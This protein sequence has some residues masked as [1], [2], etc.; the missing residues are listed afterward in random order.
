[1]KKYLFILIIISGIFTSCKNGDWEFP[2]YDYTAVYFAYQTPV[3]T[4]VIGEDVY[5][6]SLD[7]EH[8]CQIMA[9]MGGVYEN[10]AD[11]EI[12]FRV[13]NA[14]CNG[15]TFD[16]G[17]DVKP[18]PSN[19]YS[20]SSTDKIV[21]KKDEILG[22]VVVQLTDAFFTDP[23]AVKN[24]YVIPL[25]MNDVKNADKILTGTPLVDNPSRVKTDDWDVLPKDYILYAVKYISKYHANYLRRGKDVI[26]GEKNETVIRHKEYVEKDEA[27]GTYTR[28]LNTVELPL[29][30]T[31]AVG[32][33]LDCTLLLTFDDSGK[34]TV[35]SGSE[36]VAMSGSGQY[37]A[38]GEKKSWGDKDRDAIYLNYNIDFGKMQVS[39]V[40]TLV[41]RDRG[42]KPETFKPVLK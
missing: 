28:S 18:M 7:N 8:K 21:I 40:D 27:V 4:I 1:M 34:C 24:T 22:G 26:T 30:I 14:L 32:N 3:R 12:G 5:D 20:L 37:V 9:T 2:D 11:V 23:L 33:L 35:S 25:V 6:T 16:G 42:I 38:G 39:T 41:I 15:L 19:Y 17:T 29:K 13:D 10:K 31:D 36:G